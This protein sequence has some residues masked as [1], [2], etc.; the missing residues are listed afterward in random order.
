MDE[1]KTTQKGFGKKCIESASTHNE[2]KTIFVPNFV[3]PPLYF[4]LP[5]RHFFGGC[6]GQRRTIH[7]FGSV[8]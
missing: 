3:Q 8:F 1:K 5:P 4:P 2:A 7:Y 6:K